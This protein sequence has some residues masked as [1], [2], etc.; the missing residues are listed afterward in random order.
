MSKWL[1]DRTLQQSGFTLIELMVVVAIIAILAT[2]AIPSYRVYV[3]RNAESDAQR[4]MLA[5]TNEL[6]QWRAKALTYKGF[7]PDTIADSTGAINWPATNPSYII[8]LGHVTG[9]ATFSTL[10]Q[11]S[12]RAND[13]VIMATPITM[14]SASNFKI[15]SQG[16][17]CANKLS[18]TITAAGC[19]AGATTW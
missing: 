4:K 1:N 6:E 17:R 3:I 2:I 9:P 7:K 10:H 19:G 15:T 18:F 13:W 14:T 11:G 12:A 5:L 16:L 8:Q